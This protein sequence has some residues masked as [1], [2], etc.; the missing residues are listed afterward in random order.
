[1]GTKWCHIGD[2]RV[3]GEIFHIVEFALPPSAVKGPRRQ[4]ISIGNSLEYVVF[5]GKRYTL[6]E[7]LN[8]GAAAADI[9]RALGEPVENI[10]ALN[11]ADP[12]AFYGTPKATRYNGTPVAL[13]AVTT[14]T[15]VRG[16]Y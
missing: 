3:F 10:N 1:L 9:A 15:P 5:N 11:I 2:A 13:P 4:R 8:N 7:F 12:S 16:L 14:N 6:E